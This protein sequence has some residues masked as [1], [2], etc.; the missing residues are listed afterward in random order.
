MKK[1]KTIL[2]L[3]SDTHIPERASEIDTRIVDYIKL[4]RYDIVVHAGDLTEEYVIDQIKHFGKHIYVVQ[5]NMDYLDLPE[6][7]VF[8][9]Y[10]IRFGVVHGD[11]VRPR[12][13]IEALSTIAKRLGASILIS[14]HTHY[15][16]ISLDSTGILH[17]N[18]GSV[19]GVWGGGGGA[20]LPSFIELEVYSDGIVVVKLYELI[21]D[22]IELKRV[23]NYRFT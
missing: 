10:S 1:E 11:Q 7:E 16:F 4:S 9:V 5:G 15:P 23:E 18:P 21:E 8:D 20:M 6:E 22:K 17:I 2:L 12:G 19:T 13:N 3:I 14:G